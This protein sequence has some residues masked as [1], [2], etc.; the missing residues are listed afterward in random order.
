[1]TPRVCA[2]SGAAPPQALGAP[3]EAIELQGSRILP[4]KSV[5][6]AKTPEFESFLG[7]PGEYDQS[8]AQP[9]AHC[10]LPSRLP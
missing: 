5:R 9:L 8:C 6:R 2:Y 7:T 4:G 3:W 1:M 10:H